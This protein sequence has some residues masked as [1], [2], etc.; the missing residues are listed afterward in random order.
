MSLAPLLLVTGASRGIGAATARLAASR[1]WDVAINFNRDAEAAAAVA[2][3]VRAQGRQALTLQADVADDEA[4]RAMFAA[5]DAAR[6]EGR[7]GRLRG[8]VN[9][10]GVVDVAQ[11]V[12]QMS[13]QRLQRMFAVNVLGSFSC[14]REALRRMSTAHGGEGGA[15]VNLSSA[16]ARLGSPGQYV[17]YAA[18]KAAIDTFTLGLAREV[19][20]EG[21]RVNAVRPGIVETEIHASGGQPDRARRLADQVPMGRPGTAEEIAASIVWLLSDEAAYCTGACLDVTGGR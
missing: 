18:A 12:D 15:I 1:G 4:V 5:L 20:R 19:A 17:D 11:R 16:A 10:A 13:A 2:S 7:V 14:A 9:N 3:E 6:A 21:V 8:L